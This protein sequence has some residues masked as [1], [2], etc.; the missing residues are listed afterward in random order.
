MKNLT[1]ALT[2]LFLVNLAPSISFAA[3]LAKGDVN[4]DGN[5]NI[6]DAVMVMQHVL[7]LH[8]LNTEQLSA[9]DVTGEGDINVVDVTSIMR[10]SLGLIDNLG[11]EF[12][13]GSEVLMDKMLHL[14]RNKK[15]G[16]VTNQSGVNSQ[17][18]S[19]IDLLHEAEDIELVALYGPEH[20]IDGIAKAGEYV[21]SYTHPELGIPVYSLYGATR[22]PTEDML[23]GIDIL[24][25]DIQ[26][27]GARS[28]T[29]ISTLN[30]C[31]QAA[32]KYNL[33]VVVLD[34]PNPLGGTIVAGPMM[35]ERFKS[36][37]GV[38][39]LPMAHGM[40]VGELG[41]YFNRKINANL[42]VV[43]MEG[44][45]RQM[46]FQD[47]ELAW[48]RTSP[49]IPDIISAFG[50]MATG[51][52]EN[53]GVFQADQF[54]WIG[55]KG[56]NEVQYAALLNSAGLDG[57]EFIPERRGDAGGVRLKIVDYQSFN[58]ARTGIY[59]LTYAFSLGNFNIPKS[60]G[61]IVMFDKIMGT[62][63]MG[64]YLEQGLTPQKIEQLFAPGIESFKKTRQV[65]LLP[66]YGP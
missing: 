3:N 52:G 1:F 28:Y 48:V 57:V 32:A 65:Y 14:V 36:F 23:K 9:A 64:E 44:Y 42:T 8:T 39:I 17:G 15:V 63:K 56:L 43:P 27:I 50:Y 49:M 66:Q 34:R 25:Y 11:G 6:Q 10:Y 38:D 20:G 54:K 12:K 26:D 46:I 2:F 31:M 62:A 29:Y 30:Y 59:A 37:V 55:G 19:T 7:D 40:T 47:T 45:D 60:N 16:L 53:T 18:I 5:I 4:G 58:P 41:R 22:M 35:E 33:P 61:T 51:M 13:L 21:E 24:L